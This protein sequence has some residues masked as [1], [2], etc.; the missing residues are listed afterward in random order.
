MSGAWRRWLL[1]LCNS[2]RPERQERELSQ[3]LYKTHAQVNAE[4]NKRSGIK[5]VSEASIRQLEQRLHAAK[6]WLRRGR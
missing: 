4:L 2:L 3:E 5:R 1:R 6:E